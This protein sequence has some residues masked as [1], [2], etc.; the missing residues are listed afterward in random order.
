MLQ[1]ALPVLARHQ[2][3]GAEE[4]R[5]TGEQDAQR[6]ETVPQLF[7]ESPASWCKT[8]RARASSALRMRCV[9]ANTSATQ[10]VKTA[11]ASS[12]GE[13]PSAPQARAARPMRSTSRFGALT[14][15]GAA[16]ARFRIPEVTA[17]P[18]LDLS[19]AEQR[20]ERHP[21][22]LQGRRRDAA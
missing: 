6:C 3:G 21:Q 11:T 22:Q 4:G 2:V 9:A 20:R 16:R 13:R 7:G 14:G 19:P 15:S 1:I 10:A 18:S 17:T 12:T 5:G 8:S